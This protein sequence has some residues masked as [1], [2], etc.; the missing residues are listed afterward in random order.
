ML[1]WFDRHLSNAA[2]HTPSPELQNPAP[3]PV[4]VHVNL[5]VGWRELSAWPAP[6]TEIERWYLAP[7]SR[8]R[9]TPEAEQP[10]ATPLV[11]RYT[12]DPAD[13]TPAMGLASFAPIEALAEADNQALEAREDVLIYTSD[14]FDAPLTLIGDV[15]AD[16]WVT[17]STPHTDFYAR[18]TDVH[19]DGRSP[20]IAQ[21]LRRFDTPDPTGLTDQTD[22]GTPLHIALDLGPVAYRL[23]RGHRL[24]LQVASGAHPFYVRNLGTGEPLGSG[25]AMT[26]A[27]QSVRYG[28]AAFAS[29][30]SVRADR[31]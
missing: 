26:T 10:S 9:R 8:L 29:R 14:E 21:T 1:A 4:A 27:H 20:A 13:P 22:P 5:D 30:V 23:A 12:Y 3:S 16:L 18:I 19:P 15:I 28:S 7:G 24:R 17:S 25:T 2:E 11:D 31:S 6:G